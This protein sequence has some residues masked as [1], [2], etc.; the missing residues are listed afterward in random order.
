MTEHSSFLGTGMDTWWHQSQ[1]N[2]TPEK[3]PVLLSVLW[4][5]YRV[6]KQWLCRH[7]IF[8]KGEGWTMRRV[9][10][11]FAQLADSEKSE[12]Q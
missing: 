2:A 8:F 5:S 9:K 3:Q 1:V 7:V 11:R 12:A 4:S 6:A 10:C